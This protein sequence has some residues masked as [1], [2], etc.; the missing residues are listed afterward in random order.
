VIVGIFRALITTAMAQQAVWKYA[1]VKYSQEEGVTAFYCELLLW[2]RCLVQYLDKYSFKWK[3]LNGLLLG[4]HYHQAL[5]E[6]VM[7]EHSSLNEIVSK[8]QYI[9]N[10]L[11][12]LKSG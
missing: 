11:N 3:I 10:M 7:A 1:Q 9:K 5:Y 2:A 8:A 6:G 12:S 4:L